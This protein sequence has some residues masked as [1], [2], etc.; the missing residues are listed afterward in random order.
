METV[1][2]VSLVELPQ[3]RSHFSWVRDRLIGQ[4]GSENTWMNP[5]EN[6][7]VHPRNSVIRVLRDQ[8]AVQGRW[9]ERLEE[10]G[11]G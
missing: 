8:G 1:V 11:R 5:S 4:S 10:A 3:S 7:R 6:T 2:Q 9:R